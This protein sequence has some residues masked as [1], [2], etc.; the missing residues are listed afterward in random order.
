MIL[1][2]RSFTRMGLMVNRTDPA[3][4]WERGG[5]R[6]GKS[7]GCNTRKEAVKDKETTDLSEMGK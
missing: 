6:S 3:K 1:D 4:T 2:F 7:R 5:E